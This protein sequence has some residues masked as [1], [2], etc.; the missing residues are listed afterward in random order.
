[1][2]RT[3]PPNA[4]IP[5][6]SSRQSVHDVFARNRLLC[7]NAAQFQGDERDVIFFSTVDGPPDDGQLAYRDAGQ[8]DV[9]KKRYNV[10]VSRARDQRWV[11]YSIDPIAHLKSGDLQNILAIRRLCSALS[12]NM[13]PARIRHSRRR[14]CN[15]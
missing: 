11:V 2:A 7:G 15:A 8:K 6:S 10:A 4:H 13:E 3:S 5:E 12:K 14:C 9:F 1:M